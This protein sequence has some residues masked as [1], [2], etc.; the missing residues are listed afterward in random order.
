METEIIFFKKWLK[1]N[2]KLLKVLLFITCN[3]NKENVC[4]CNIND[5]CKWLDI[6]TSSV[7]KNNIKEILKELEQKNYIKFKEV[8]K[9][10]YNITIINSAA[11]TDEQI[12]GIYKQWVL[13][14]RQTK[15]NNKNNAEEKTISI[16]YTISIKILIHCF[17]GNL[18]GVMTQEEI[19]KKIDVSKD[20]ICDA[21]KILKMCKF[22][23]ISFI[24]E[25]IKADVKMYNESINQVEWKRKNVGTQVNIGLEFGT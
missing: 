24:S 22:K 8:K 9:N 13:E 6:K 4:I 7:N 20:S 10:N 12:K 18:K 16:D 14:V 15:I 2:K 23:S 19:G 25:T 3:N 11:E 17:I 5:I 1:E 21:I